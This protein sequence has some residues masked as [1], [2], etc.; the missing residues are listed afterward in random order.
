MKIHLLGLAATGL[1]AAACA[2]VETGPGPMPPEEGASQ[3]RADHYQRYI[4]RNRSELPARPEGEIWRVTC[5]TCPVTMDYNPNRLNILYDQSSG[6][7]RE[8]KCG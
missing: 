6:V 1:L 3:C 7:V 8:V 2:P 4:G 5:T